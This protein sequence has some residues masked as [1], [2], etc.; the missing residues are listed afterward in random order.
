MRINANPNHPDYRSD[1]VGCHVYLGDRLMERVIA[2]DDGAGEVEVAIIDEQ[3]L[4]AVDGAGKPLTE[5]HHGAVQI[6]KF[7][8]WRS[9]HRIGYE[10]WMSRRI[11]AAHQR[12]MKASSSLPA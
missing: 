8:S 4:I 11:E 7:G 10:A 2:A 6:V 3:G 9:A 5:V 1:Y 12:F